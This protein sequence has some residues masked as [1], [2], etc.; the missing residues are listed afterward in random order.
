MKD[1]Q[2]RGENDQGVRSETP[3]IN[4]K[5]Y[6]RL[7]AWLYNLPFEEHVELTPFEEL[8]DRMRTGQIEGFEISTDMQPFA[9]PPGTPNKIAVF[10]TTDNQELIVKVRYDPTT[11]QIFPPV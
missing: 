2:A 7:L 4:W 9:G 10:R 1:R 3:P 6:R 11:N 5:V 8:S